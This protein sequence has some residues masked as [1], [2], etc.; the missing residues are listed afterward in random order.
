MASTTQ[1]I[2]KAS[3][4]YFLALAPV[5]WAKYCDRKSR[6]TLYDL[7]DRLCWM[8]AHLALAY[9]YVQAREHGEDHAHAVKRA[10]RQYVKVRKALG[11]TYYNRPFDF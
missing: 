1:Y 7:A 6:M 4:A 2:T 3:F 9:G 10:Q 11:Y 5:R 8:C